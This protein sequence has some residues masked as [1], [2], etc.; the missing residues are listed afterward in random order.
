VI[1]TLLY[2]DHVVVVREPQVGE[3]GHGYPGIVWV[4]IMPPAEARQK[5]RRGPSSSFS[6]AT[7]RS[8]WAPSVAQALDNAVTFLDLRF[9]EREAYS[10]EEV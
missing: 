2:R 6:T 3:Y 4:D 1:A 8:R 10:W 9:T 7:V 5:S